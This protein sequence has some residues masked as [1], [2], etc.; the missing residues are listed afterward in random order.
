MPMMDGIEAA[1]IIRRD[2]GENGAAPAIIAQT[3][4]AMEGMR[5]RFL[6]RGFQDFITKPMDRRLLDQLLL[7][8]VPEARRQ[9]RTGA[10]EESSPDPA[11]EGQ[12]PAL[13]GPEL[14]ERLGE[15]LAQLEDFRSRE[16]AAS[17]EELLRREL[18]PEVRDSLA[19]IHA[20]LKLYEDERAE[21]LLSQLYDSLNGQM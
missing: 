11:A 16:C 18:A 2:C 21:K 15:A 19:Q 1:E 9:S 5:Q 20:Q 7:R 4:N 6:D 10:G 12:L 8:W 13:S 14:I 3:A 17:V